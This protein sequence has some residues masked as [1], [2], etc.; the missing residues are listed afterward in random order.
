MRL[1]KAKEEKEMVEMQEKARIKMTKEAQ[2]IERLYKEEEIKKAFDLQKKEKKE[3]MSEKK[4][5]LEQLR[6]DKEERFGKQAPGSIMTTEGVVKKSMCGLELVA[7]GIKTV[8]TLYIESR[9][10]GVAKTCFK[11]AGIFL[12]NILK[13]PGEDK[14]KS[15]KLSNN[16]FHTRVGK[17]NGGLAILKGAGFVENNEDNLVMENIDEMLIREAIRLLENNQ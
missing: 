6:I 16:A 7:H 15:I 2:E 3:F 9:A 4:K 11:T 5:M 10:P 1:K 12:S 13:N 14:Y 17:I 8:K